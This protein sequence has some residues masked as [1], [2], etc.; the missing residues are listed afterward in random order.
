MPGVKAFWAVPGLVAGGH[1]VR[2]RFDG[3]PEQRARW[4]GSGSFVGAVEKVSRPEEFIEG[5]K[6]ASSVELRVYEVGHRFVEGRFDY[7]GAQ[8][9]IAEV[10]RRCGLPDD[11]TK[12]ED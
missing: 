6:R 8:A 12:A 3:G 7:S 5:L 11:G 4:L 10:A 1:R 2:Y 9:A